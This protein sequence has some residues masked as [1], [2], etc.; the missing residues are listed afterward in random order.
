MVK[1]KLT[2]RRGSIN[3]LSA[4]H[5]LAIAS[6]SEFKEVLEPHH[7]EELNS[8]LRDAEK[9]S[10]LVSKA[11]SFVCEY[12]G[13]LIG[14]AYLMP[15]GNPMYVFEAEWSVIRMVGVLPQYRGL[16]ISKTLTQQCIEHAKQTGESVIA[17][18]TSEFMNAARHIY[19]QLG[20][21]QLREIDPLFGKRYWLYTL[22]LS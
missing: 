2:Y 14:A 10:D 12:E 8:R 15:S 11:A 7:F 3:D 17:L 4:L 6:Y 18:H 16:G 5:Q 1:D 19:E 21:T 13:Q 20:F 9:F 22:R